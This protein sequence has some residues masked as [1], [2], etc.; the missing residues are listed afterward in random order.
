[1]QERKYTEIEDFLADESFQSWVRTNVDRKKGNMDFRKSCPRK[2]VQESR[3]WL[4]ATK[5]R[6]IIPLLSPNRTTCYL[7]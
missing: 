3:L 4:L 5:V 2:L 7:E 1:M 6:K